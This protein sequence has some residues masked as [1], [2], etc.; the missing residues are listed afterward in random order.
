MDYRRLLR[1]AALPIVDRR[2]AAPLSAVALGFGVFVGVAIGPG[3]AGTFATGAT[4]IVELADIGEGSGGEES[5][6]AR[7]GAGPPAAA[8]DSGH[9]PAAPEGEASDAF[10]PIPS[11][12]PE[13]PVFAEAGEPPATEDEPTPSPEE[14]ASPAEVLAG[15]VVH[16]N[17]AAGSYVVASP[18]G[19]MSAVHAPT[20]PAPGTE[21]EVP[22][23]PLAN[24]TFAEAGRRVRSATR[25]RA[26]IAGVVTYVDTSPAGPAYTVSG[27]GASILVHVPPDPAGLAPELPALGSQA[28][29]KVAIRKRESLAL[30]AT[31]APPATGEAIAPPDEATSEPSCAPDP[32]Q[33][34]S[35]VS[36]P[37]VLWQRD[38][39]TDDSP[40]GQG[41]LAGI[42]VAICPESGELLLS[43]DDIRE[44]G[45]ELTLDISTDVD[46]D[47]LQPGDPVVARVAV[48]PDGALSLT[49][50]ADDERVR[51][52]DDETALRGDLVAG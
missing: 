3:A 18:A 4:R 49:G 45:K 36:F 46:L 43:A 26:A 10:A 13:G 20:A 44:S 17:R 19:E 9:V 16:L 39:E 24:G 6:E 37:T 33:S 31:E 25:S 30:P 42:V 11:S 2:W 12:E 47:G 52:A 34:P 1:W 48:A 5:L 51:G 29:A 41:D 7:T 35:P 32:D 21:V 22:V 27:R 23:R 40:L 28:K 8:P 14:P 15:V 38:V 50:L